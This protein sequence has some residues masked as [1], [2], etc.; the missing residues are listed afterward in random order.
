[1]Y[2]TL[3]YATATQ[4]ALTTLQP[5]PLRSTCF[6]SLS[7][8][9]RFGRAIAA[10]KTT[11]EAIEEIGEVVEGFPTAKEAVLLA[12]RAGLGRKDLPLYHA[13]ADVLHG[14]ADVT[15]ALQELLSMPSGRELFVERSDK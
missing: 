8:N 7:R 14:D 9:N 3:C 12:Q 1:M 11:E 5:H 10:G 4:C 6:S 15:T 2:A 13:I